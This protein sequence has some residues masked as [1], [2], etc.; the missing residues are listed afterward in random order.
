MSTE[1]PVGFYGKLPMLGDFVG[2]R[3]PERVVETWDAWLQQAVAASKNALAERWLE[4]YLTAPMWRFFAHP[5]VLAEQAVAGVVFPSVDRVGRYFPFTVFAVLPADTVGLIVADRCAGWFERVEDLV[6]AQLEEENRAVEDF[7]QALAAT[8]SILESALAAVSRSAWLTGFPAANGASGDHLHLPLGEQLDVGPTALGW[9][10]QSLVRSTGSP[11][12]WWTGGSNVVRPCWLLTRG[13]PDP[14]AFS[15]MLAG[16]WQEWPWTSFETHA[17]EA[18][19]A[20]PLHLE[21]A[22][23]THPGKVRDE[24]QDA[25][26]SCPEDGLWAVADGM[27]G[28]AEGQVASQMV[29]DALTAVGPRS[30]LAESVTAVRDALDG[31]NEY[32]HSM[33]LRRVNPVV[34]GT[35]VVAMLVR[36]TRGVCLWAGDS[37]LYRLR[38][39]VLEQLTEDHSEAGE[40]SEA[41]GHAPRSNVITR[42][43]GG[44][45]GLELDQLSFD[46][47]LGDRFLLCSDGLYR[48]I[49]PAR[50]GELL[51][52]GDAATTVETLI[53]HALRGEAADNITVVVVDAQ[54]ST[55]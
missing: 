6:L 12:Y 9:L 46:V 2:R 21:S 10:D 29:R 38:D 44:R 51:Q 20:S 8:G 25:F 22:G 37:R 49:Q 45:D 4:L 42:A 43:I 53:E 54:P 15:A 34:S 40:A 35:T 7:E 33:S 47:R 19:P 28:H 11:V 55:A 50:I 39:A 3:V 13:L 14:V 41:S 52:H 27:G 30:S 32:L 48:D 31:V 26:V 17:A 24:N 18:A 16:D 1:I 23:S 5:G 36:G